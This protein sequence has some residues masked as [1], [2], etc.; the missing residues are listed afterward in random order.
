MITGLDAKT[1]HGSP[2]V[3]SPLMGPT[4][5]IGGP[6]TELGG[7]LLRSASLQVAPLNARLGPGAFLTTD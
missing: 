5:A 1:G 4:K 3:R 7:V 2:P 6:G